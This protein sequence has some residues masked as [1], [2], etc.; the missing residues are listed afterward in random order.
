MVV[1]GAAVLPV[2]VDVLMLDVGVVVGARGWWLS[3]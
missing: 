1:V 2:V 3:Y